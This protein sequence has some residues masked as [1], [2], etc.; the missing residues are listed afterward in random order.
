MPGASALHPST[1]NKTMAL[2]LSRDRIVAKK[3]AARLFFNNLDSIVARMPECRTRE[4]LERAAMHGWQARMDYTLATG[5]G[6]ELD[7]ALRRE[8]DTR[9]AM[10]PARREAFAQYIRSKP[11][12][13]VSFIREAENEFGFTVEEAY[14]RIQTAL[15]FAQLGLSFPP[16]AE[17][18]HPF[19]AVT[20]AYK[21]GFPTNK[22][23]TRVFKLALAYALPIS[24][25]RNGEDLAAHDKGSP[26][27]P[28]GFPRVPSECM[29][30]WNQL[31][32][33]RVRREAEESGVIAA[34]YKATNTNERSFNPSPFEANLPGD[35]AAA[36]VTIR[37]GI[38][39]ALRAKLA[40]V[41]SFTVPPK[42]SDLAGESVYDATN[43]AA[44]LCM[45]REA[46]S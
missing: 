32:V 46:Q 25:K 6:D 14:E 10:A 41:E 19:A 11:A 23:S 15:A 18:Q 43:A 42:F 30:A 17:K 44:V 34:F 28:F 39:S 45:P 12:F 35:P 9:R 29:V 37:D 36:F 20:H 33:E 21:D 16:Y 4:E 8:L 13:V 22:F 3:V 26:G 31:E 27:Y 5:P 7:N 2:T 24:W 40:M 38:A 1:E